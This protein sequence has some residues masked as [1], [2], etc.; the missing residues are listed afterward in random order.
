M[1][2]ATQIAVYSAEVGYS[3][4]A[5]TRCER[6]SP[7][8]HLTLLVI[9][10]FSMYWVVAFEKTGGITSSTHDG[11]LTPDDGNTGAGMTYAHWGE[12]RRQNSKN[13][14]LYF[15]KP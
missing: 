3:V 8:S 1:I 4:T 5:Y 10:F 12:Y 9:T 14:G 6:F 2:R 13:S 11:F 7:T 15:L